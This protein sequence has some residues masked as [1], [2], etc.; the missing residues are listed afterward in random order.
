MTQVGAAT[1]HD[2]S[3]GK[4]NDPRLNDW[5]FLFKHPIGYGQAWLH[6]PSTV[7][8]AVIRPQ[9][10]AVS[11]DATALRR[12]DW[13]YFERNPLNPILD[14]AS[15]ASVGGKALRVGG[16]RGLL[17]ARAA[18]FTNAPRTLTVG[19]HTEILRQSRTL[20][21]QIRQRLFDRYSMAY[22]D[23]PLTGANVRMQGILSKR[24][25]T[26]ALRAGLSAREF[27]QATNGLT[28]AEVFAFHVGAEGVPLADRM[29][30]YQA[31]LAERTVETSGKATRPLQEYL[32]NLDAPA[33]KDV[34][35]N[36]R[37]QFITALQLG[38]ELEAKAGQRLVETGQ[39][40]RAT[41]RERA[42]LPQREM[43]KPP[44]APG[45]GIRDQ[46][47]ARARE[48]IARAEQSG[49]IG[50]FNLND[51]MDRYVP[52]E[53]IPGSVSPE[54]ADMARSALAR[55]DALEA[56]LG[57]AIA[58]ETNPARIR[59]LEQRIEAGRKKLDRVL[60]GS[61]PEYAALAAEYRKQARS[62]FVPRHAPVEA[63]RIAEQGANLVHPDFPAP[64][65]FP[66][67][68]TR[69]SQASL[70]RAP[71]TQQMLGKAR[72]LDQLKHNAAVR[73]RNAFVLIDP[74]KVLTTDFLQT[75]RHE[76][77]IQMQREA[78]DPISQPL[79]ETLAGQGFKKD[80]EF[81]YRPSYDR[82]QTAPIERGVR[83]APDLTQDR[84]ILDTQARESGVEKAASGVVS[85]DIKDLLRE[86]ETLPDA[87]DLNSLAKLNELGIRRVPAAF[88]KDFHQQ[89]V[90]TH[91]AVRHFLDRPLDV[92]RAITLNY[93]PAWAVNNFVGNGLMGLATYGPAGAA[94]Y[95]RVLLSTERGEDK[96][97]RLRDYTMRVPTLRRK[98]G[99]VFGELGVAPELHSAGLF[100]TQTRI[101]HK[102]ITEGVGL[103]RFT[104][105]P[106]VS[107]ALGLPVKAITKPVMAFGRGVTKLEV[108]LAE[109]T[110]REAA[111]ILEAGG[112][113][114][115]IRATARKLGEANLKTR[116]ALQRLDRPSVE[117]AVRGTADAFG[118]FNDLSPIERSVIRRA[119]P[120]YSWYKVITK[121]SGKY[122]AR[123]PARIL[124][125]KN[126]EDARSTK[127]EAPLPSWLAGA[128]RLGKPS[129]G[130]QTVLSTSGINPYE[131][132]PQTL[133]SG[134]GGMLNPLAQAAIT[135]YTG[136]DPRF[137]P[138]IRYYGWG[139]TDQAG[140]PGFAERFGGAFASG[141]APSQLYVHTTEPPKSRAYAP[142]EYARAGPISVNDYLL[143]Y[144]G[145]P[146]RHVRTGTGG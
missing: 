144:L 107:K 131:T 94:W 37:P 113:L 139:A 93:R 106:K 140:V 95:L 141:L 116:D 58:A 136:N 32:A 34:L 15:V 110:A 111:F 54:Y 133:E 31:Q 72:S 67:V 85:K 84:N 146:L 135:G 120:F 109:D 16:E 52:S 61:D 33:V 118:D 29:A 23:R 81:Y 121:V 41:R 119:I 43:M 2:L 38:K 90:R 53:F 65:R 22:P 39:L 103:D 40:T 114:A 101:T 11:R 75:A 50:H 24:A 98:Y 77:I 78:L 42:L 27:E 132:I 55:Q 45:L 122:A 36:P 97:L 51:P 71:G 48:T 108:L 26:S 112:D 143:Q 18:E 3:G 117:A 89:Y 96:V 104:L 8:G 73:L 134:P 9:I 125:L 137:G 17:G 59:Q 19:D 88:G 130:V 60:S 62:G 4:V 87:R 57:D 56:E 142:K 126:I 105:N 129:G 138:N 74:H 28:P 82:K 35:E 44:E 12:G 25:A 21:G 115:K 91:W 5:S 30:Y 70:Y 1:W 76:E 123:Y 145:L 6:D 69:K 100:G 102:G 128:I 47:E 63:P 124:M 92:W 68:G 80:G 49:D 46:M 79:S 64:F 10:T 20:Q 99:H 86:G 14:V 66:H 127:G 13:G 83:E 7:G